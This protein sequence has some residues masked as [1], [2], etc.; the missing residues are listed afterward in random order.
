[1]TATGAASN[2]TLGQAFTLTISAVP[3]WSTTGVLGSAS[4]GTGYSTTVS[5]TNGVTYTVTGGALPTGLSLSS[6]GVLSGTPTV[7]GTW[8]WTIT[9]TGTATNAVARRAFSLVTA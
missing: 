2:A 4:V 7:A 1:M 9:A 8:T 5:A 6:G 3:V